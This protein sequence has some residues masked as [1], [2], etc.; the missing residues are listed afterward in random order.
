MV[1]STQ[2]QRLCENQSDE[3][4]DCMRVP[5]TDSQIHPLQTTPGTG[6]GGGGRDRYETQQKAVQN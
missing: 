3:S 5:A 6:E 1:T 2:R 4:T